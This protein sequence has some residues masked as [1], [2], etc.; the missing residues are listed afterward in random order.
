MNGPCP[1]HTLIITLSTYTFS[2]NRTPIVSVPVNVP[3]R[4]HLHAGAPT[5]WE[6]LHPG[7]NT[8]SVPC[9]MLTAHMIPPLSFVPYKLSR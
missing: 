7:A 9:F 4:R 2:T 3:N 1:F 8:S 6:M 5:S